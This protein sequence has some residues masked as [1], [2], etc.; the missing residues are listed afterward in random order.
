MAG[1]VDH[2]FGP[3]ACHG[4]NDVER[5]KPF[6]MLIIGGLLTSDNPL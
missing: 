3:A 2:L 6:A 5:A 1:E 4:L